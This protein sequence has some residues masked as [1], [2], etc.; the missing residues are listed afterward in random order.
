MKASGLVIRL[1][2]I[3]LLALS[4]MIICASMTPVYAASA[5][6]SIS[7]TPKSASVK[8]GN[9]ITYHINVDAPQNFVDTISFTLS[10]STPGHDTAVDTS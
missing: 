7:I 10:V 3:G 6:F 9:T 1:G 2:T 8:P 5:P 4:S